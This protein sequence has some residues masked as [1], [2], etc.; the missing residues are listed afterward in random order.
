[1]DEAVL[2]RKTVA[3]IQELEQTRDFHVSPLNRRIR[4]VVA[5]C[6]C[7]GHPVTVLVVLNWQEA[8]ECVQE[9]NC[10]DMLSVFVNHAIN[11]GL[12]LTSNLRKMVGKLFQVLIDEGVLTADGFQAGYVLA[13]HWV[14]GYC[15][16]WLHKHV[17][18]RLNI[19]LQTK[20]DM[21]R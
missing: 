3:I 18:L 14:C 15:P 16:Y 7:V 20:H 2:E 12:E 4:L 10:P 21:E 9:M 17:R 11:H 5:R 8:V 6:V 13:P 19:K 1:M